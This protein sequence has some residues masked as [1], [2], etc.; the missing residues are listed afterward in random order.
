MILSYKGLQDREG[1][2]AAGVKLPKQ[3]WKEM[4]AETAARPVWVH[5]GD[6]KS[7]RLNSSHPT[8]SRMPSSA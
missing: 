5:F 4:C 6:R 7:T 2:E 8:T 3:D 1:W